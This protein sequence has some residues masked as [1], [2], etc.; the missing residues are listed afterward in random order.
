MIRFSVSFVLITLLAWAI[1]A[2]DSG[3]R[4]T[5]PLPPL[6]VSDFPLDVGTHWV[7][8]VVDTVSGEEDTVDARI[9]SERL[10]PSGAR[11]TTW[12]YSSR[13]GV[14]QSDSAIVI[15]LGDTV[16]FYR[17]YCGDLP[18]Q[19]IIFPISS[20]KAWEYVSGSGFD[21]SLV[22]GDETILTPFKVFRTYPIETTTVP[23]S[24]DA[25]NTSRLWL[26]KDY[27][28]VRITRIVG[29][30]PGPELSRARIWN[31]LDHEALADH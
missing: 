19:K 3:S 10:E 13:N 23:F 1:A 8:H 22:L 18:Y 14:F 20:G 29:R 31:L 15:V 11:V 7:Y 16:W 4:P 12:H 24:M 2:C 5:G 30:Y 6:T 25:F 27:G 21:S 17:C 28:L 9:S 26:A